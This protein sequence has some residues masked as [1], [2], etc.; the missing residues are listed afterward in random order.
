MIPKIIHFCW[1][2]KGEY[3]ET[4]KKCIASWEEKLPDYTIKKW[5]ETNTPFD[6][7][8]FLRLLYKQKKWSFITDYV[9][10]YAL[11]KEGGIYL[12]TDIE[13]LKRFDELHTE[14]AFT[15]FQTDMESSPFPVAAGIIGAKKGDNFILDC[16]KE[17]EKKQR[18]KFNGMGGP[19]ILTKVL[20]GYGLA[21]YK[22]QTINKVLV[23]DKRYF[24]PFYITEKFT[25]DCI[26]E[27]TICIHW[28]QDSWGNKKKG[29]KYI[30]DSLGRK[31]QKT[32][33]IIK[34]KI[35]FNINKERFY[36][37][38]NKL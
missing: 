11:Y 25:Q 10:L 4:I 5:D 22:T 23:L 31:L 19:P 38:N 14:E 21:E 35:S 26:D 34:N 32:P 33:L 12:D 6:K 17:T 15:G 8:P 7:L 37:I 13:I 9:R 20:L 36:F 27:E 30:L 3:N 2:G 1:Y 18:L 24:Y 29:I 28:W 16:I